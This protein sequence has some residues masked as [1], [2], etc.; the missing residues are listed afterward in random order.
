MAEAVTYGASTR[1]PGVVLNVLGDFTVTLDDEPVALG[2]PRQRAVLARIL[3]GG[4]EAVSAEQ[5]VDD[6]W[7]E[8]SADSTLASVHAYVSLSLIHI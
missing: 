6:V 8:H 5:I 1:G 4:E 2:G 3:A 7:G